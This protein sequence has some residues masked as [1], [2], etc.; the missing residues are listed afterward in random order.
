MRH[1]RLLLPRSLGLI[2]AA[3]SVYDVWR[4]FPMTQRRWLVIHV[5]RQGLRIVTGAGAFVSGTIGR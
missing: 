4:R 2:G 3:L 1:L 5:R